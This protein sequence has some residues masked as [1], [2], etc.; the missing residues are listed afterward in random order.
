MR[1]DDQFNPQLNTD[2]LLA[3][4]CQESGLFSR[5]H[6]TPNV[7]GTGMPEIDGVTS[8]V[9][10]IPAQ[11]RSTSKPIT[12]W[13]SCNWAPA[14][15]P[16][17]PAAETDVAIV[18]AARNDLEWVLIAPS[19]SAVQSDVYPRPILGRRRDDWRRGRRREIRRHGRP[20]DQHC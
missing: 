5:H 17:V 1:S 19:P 8:A 2:C 7:N 15:P 16:T 12:T 3:E 6:Y 20:G 9:P 14:V 18:E 10:L 13:E 11:L 4:T